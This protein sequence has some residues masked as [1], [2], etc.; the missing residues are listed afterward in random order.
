M[1][2]REKRSIEHFQ[3]RGKSSKYVASKLGVSL[4]TVKSYMQRHDPKSVVKC[5]HCGEPF[6][7]NPKRNVRLFCSDKCRSKWWNIHR[8]EIDRK[9][10]Y[11]IKCAY[12]GEEFEVY[13]RKNQ[14]YCNRECYMHAHRKGEK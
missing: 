6:K 4:N 3:L 5:L 13:G 2:E 1:T 10:I 9:A 7:A 12:C 11:K 14:K 8:N